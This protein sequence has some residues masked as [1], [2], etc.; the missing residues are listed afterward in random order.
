MRALVSA[1]FLA[2]ALPS[3]GWAQIDEII[4][5]AMERGIDL[6]GIVVPKRGDFFVLSI[7]VSNDRLEEDARK[8]EFD[9]TIDSL[10]A[11]AAAQP[12]IGLG[13]NSDGIVQPLT[14]ANRDYRLDV[15]NC[16]ERSDIRCTELLI[17]TKVPSAPGETNLSVDR[18]E[19]FVTSFEPVGRTS[20]DV[21]GG[22]DVT[23]VN[24]HQYRTEI[25]DL[26]LAE[27]KKVRTSFGEGYEVNLEGINEKVHVSRSGID[28]VV[29]YI[30]Y[31]YEI[32]WKPRSVEEPANRR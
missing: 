3:L 23:I 10:F 28:E 6:P 24:P 13:V 18:L 9:R 17:R 1:F 4:V 16:G 19:E 27:I 11:A 2:V 26:V 14:S 8:S 29:V 31:E 22:V 5:T 12:E 30:P 15:G 25:L 20:V 21:L 32:F 7:G